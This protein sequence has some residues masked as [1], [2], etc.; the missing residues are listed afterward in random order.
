MSRI[1]QHY[2]RLAI[3]AALWATACSALRADQSVSLG[4]KPSPDDVAGYYVCYGT[5]TG[6]YDSRFDVGT[7]T[8]AVVTNL[9]NGTYFFAVIAYD[10]QGREAE[11]SNEVS[12]SVPTLT[13]DEGTTLTFT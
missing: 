13:V 10:E 12:A 5:A 1:N 2:R 9:A 7:N 6:V 8:T 11:P 3:A 4:W